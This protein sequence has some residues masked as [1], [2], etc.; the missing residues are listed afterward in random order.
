M[1]TSFDIARRISSR[2]RRL[3]SGY[4]TA[5][6][7]TETGAMSCLTI[8]GRAYRATV[9][10]LPADHVPPVGFTHIVDGPRHNQL[11]IATLASKAVSG[12]ARVA[13]PAHEAIDPWHKDGVAS[14]VVRDRS[15]AGHLV[16]VFE[17]TFDMQMAEVE[18]FKA[19]SA[20]QK[21]A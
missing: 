1:L 6:L 5:A 20:D 10:D 18:A 11:T 19:R 21:N 13:C 16:E 17:Y 12:M 3:P 4:A 15:G 9:R 7:R 8:G 2:L 14:F